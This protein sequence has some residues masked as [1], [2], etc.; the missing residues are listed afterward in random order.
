MRA[1]YAAYSDEAE[2]VTQ[3]VSQIPW[4]HNIMLFQKL[5]DS[6][7]RLRYAAKVLEHGW[8]RAVLDHQVETDLY[9]RQGG[10]P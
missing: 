2:F 4:G 3:A 1:F 6:E 7:R 9:G 8:I 5:K 10:R